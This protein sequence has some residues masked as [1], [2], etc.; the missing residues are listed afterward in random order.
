MF[1][2]LRI[3]QEK[4][5]DGSLDSACVLDGCPIRG[6]STL[7]SVCLIRKDGAREMAT[8][9]MAAEEVY[10]VERA[11]LRSPAAARQTGLSAARSREAEH[12]NKMKSLFAQVIAVA[13]LGAYRTLS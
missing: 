7:N 1:L 5:V 10:S 11:V 12:L 6:A 9:G 3:A 4:A 8:Q 13:F 2:K